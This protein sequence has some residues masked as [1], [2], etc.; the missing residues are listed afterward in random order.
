MKTIKSSSTVKQA[1]II[2][3]IICAV[4]AMM[5]SCAS[6]KWYRSTGDGCQQSSGMSGFGNK[7]VSHK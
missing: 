1:I 5:A 4:S 3:V 7:L 6:A 2:I